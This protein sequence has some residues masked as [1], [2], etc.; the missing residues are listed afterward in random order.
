MSEWTQTFAADRLPEFKAILEK[1][2][3]RLRKA[4]APEFIPVISEPFLKS[5]TL[6]GGTEVLVEFVT[7][8]L[9]DYKLA[10]GDF[11]FVASLVPEEAGI[12]IHTA[13]GESLDGFCPEEFKCDHCKVSRHRTRN[14]IVRDNRDGSLVQL[15][16]NCIELYTGLKPKGLWVLDFSTE[17]LAQFA[18]DEGGWGGGGYGSR[19]YSV[20]IDTVLR[21][22]YVYSDG[23]R[24][25]ISKAKAY[26][27]DRNA[28]VDM[29]RCHL[30]SPPKP[31]YDREGYEDYL[32]KGRE[33]AALSDE[34]LDAIKASVETVK[35][36]S[37]YGYNLRTI[38]AAPSGAVGY[39][40]VGVLGSLVA[41]YRRTLEREAKAKA[42]PAPGGFLGEPGQ[43][44][45]TGLRLTLKRVRFLDGNYGIT[46]ILVGQSEDGHAVEWFASGRHDYDE[47]DVLVISAF[48]IKGQKPAGSDEYT[49][50]DTTVITRA[51]IVEAVVA[52]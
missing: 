28:T 42:A 3:R 43:R 29:V 22:A 6:E 34:I 39:R 32:A 45:K 21:L 20:L 8:S 15:G 9:E 19:D 18:K 48:T 13:P 36:D 25:Y 16:H 40:N 49:R 33:A 11:T 31:Q 47:G 7:A 14:Y 30:F 5:I 17:Q 38:L 46:T 4:G 35:G 10:L 1:A 52:A 26:E 51:K 50:A 2:N 44:I 12:T 23:G 24:N 41:V 27:W 37:D